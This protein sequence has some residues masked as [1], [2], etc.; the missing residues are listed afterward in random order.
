[1]VG[2]ETKQVKEQQEGCPQRRSR[3]AARGSHA[4]GGR[5]CWTAPATRQSIVGPCLL[6][7]MLVDDL[8]D[9]GSGAIQGQARVIASPCCRT[10]HEGMAQL[11][12]M[13]RTPVAQDSD[14]C[15]WS[16]KRL[17]LKPKFRTKR[18]SASQTSSRTSATTSGWYGHP[19]DRP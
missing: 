19:G 7:A 11:D 8:K 5:E 14:P 9:G 18:C 1:M 4:S 16:W 2:V 6:V 10:K 15:R 3:S 17:K 13:I 12:S